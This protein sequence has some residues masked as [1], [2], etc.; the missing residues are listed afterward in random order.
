MFNPG[1]KRASVLGEFGGLGLP[2]EDHLWQQKDNWGY[3]TYKTQVELQQNYE[4]LIHKLRPLI[5]KGLAAAVYTQTTDVEGEVNG[6]LTYDRAV[7]KLDVEK[8]AAL[9]KKLYEPPPIFTIEPIVATSEDEPQT[10]KY[11]IAKP[12]DGWMKPDFDEAKWAEGRG[13]FGE[14]STPGS[15]VITEWKS[16]DI[17]L[18]RNFELK[19]KPTGDV[20]LRLHHDEDIIVYINGVLAA[21]VEGYVV[22]YFEL[23]ISAEAKAALKAGK[24]TIAIHCHQTGGGQY[25]DAGLVEVVE[26]PRK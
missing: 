25:I 26:K 21:K 2:V 17:W 9:H 1:E 4:L 6:L 16:P 22:D 23:P 3:R 24:N 13:G 19:E 18:R 10:W 14:R 20:Q 15:H 11:T 7:V 5:S 8:I 12:D